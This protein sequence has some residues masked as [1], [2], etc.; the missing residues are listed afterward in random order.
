LAWLLLR[1]LHLSVR[2]PTVLPPPSLWLK[3]REKIGKTDLKMTRERCCAYGRLSLLFL[4][5]HGGIRLVC[6]GDHARAPTKYSKS[7]VFDSGRACYLSCSHGSCVPC[8]GGGYVMA[9]STF[10]KRGFGAPSHR[11][12]RLLLLF[13]G[14]ELHHL[15]PSGVLH[16][17]AFVTLCEAYMGIEPHFNLWNYFYIQLRQGS[18]T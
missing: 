10:Y 13:Y 7:G 9:C 1:N 14:L 15:T 8:H 6:I 12:L 17:V 18:G 2:Y 5:F 4:L 16:I 11:F 3:R